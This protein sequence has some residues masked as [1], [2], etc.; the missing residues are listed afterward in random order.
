MGAGC[1]HYPLLP[2]EEAQWELWGCNALW[3]TAFDEQDQFR[4]DRWFEMHPHFAQSPSDLAS[5]QRAPVDVYVL[6][7][8]DQS[9]VPRAVCYPRQCLAERQDTKASYASTFAYQ[10]A[11]A[12]WQGFS[13]IRLAGIYMNQGREALSERPNLLYWIGLAEGLGVTV[14]LWTCDPDLVRHPYLYGYHYTEEKAYAEQRCRE[15]LVGLARDGW[16]GSH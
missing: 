6:S 7:W 9:W 8:R 11:L 1:H 15:S 3:H 12:V 14:E 4:A 2:H 16:R 13:T 5:L 10:I